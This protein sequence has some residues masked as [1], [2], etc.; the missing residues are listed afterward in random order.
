MGLWE[1]ERV[2][3]CEARKSISRLSRIWTVAAATYSGVHA[4]T[5]R[6]LTLAL[7]ALACSA[8]VASIPDR[9]LPCK[10][11]GRSI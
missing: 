6:C 5:I 2:G 8:P 9:R 11:R 1:D 3:N 7:F 10:R 4:E